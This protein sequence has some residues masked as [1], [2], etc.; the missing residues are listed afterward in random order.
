MKYNPKVQFNLINIVEDDLENTPQKLDVLKSRLGVSNFVITR[1]GISKFR[2]LVFDK[3]GIDIP[4][5]SSWYYKLCDFKPTLAYLFPELSPEDKYAYWGY[6][7]MDVIWG[8]FSRYAYL[9]QGNYPVIISG[10]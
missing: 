9:F 6:V 1:I 2:N 10:W 7:D 5:N 3:L 8:N 4:F